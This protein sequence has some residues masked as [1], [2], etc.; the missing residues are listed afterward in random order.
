MPENEPIRRFVPLPTQFLQEEEPSD[1][2]EDD[3]EQNVEYNQPLAHFQH[4]AARSALT[5]AQDHHVQSFSSGRGIS[6][7]TFY[8][9]SQRNLNYG[10]SHDVV[11]DMPSGQTLRNFVGRH[12]PKNDDC[13][14]NSYNYQEVCFKNFHNRIHSVC[15]GD[16]MQ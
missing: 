12:I 15:L 13:S 10:Q 11:D 9:I 4:S 2:D 6:S 16:D 5:S 7:S 8:G 3:D 1:I 14:Q